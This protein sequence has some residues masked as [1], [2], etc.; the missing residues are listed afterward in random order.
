[1]NPLTASNWLSWGARDWIHPEFQPNWRVRSVCVSMFSFGGNP[2]EK[3]KVAQS[4][5]LLREE[6]TALKEKR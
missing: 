1:M 5:Q 6:P 2:I 4:L 3:L